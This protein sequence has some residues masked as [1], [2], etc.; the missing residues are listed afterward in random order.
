MHLPQLDPWTRELM[1]LEF[2]ADWRNGL[3]YRK[4]SF[5]DTTHRQWL[6]MLPRALA[7]GTP[8][9]LTRATQSAFDEDHTMLAEGEFIHYYSRAICGRAIR[10]GRPVVRE[11]RWR[12]SK[13]PRPRFGNGLWEPT[14]LQHE[15]RATSVGAGRS[16]PG[17]GSGITVEF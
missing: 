17:I 4:E 9:S 3:E 16:F 7:A 2:E 15:L 10:R 11:V 1:T 12:W 8:A 6:A 14:K 5:S 13:Y